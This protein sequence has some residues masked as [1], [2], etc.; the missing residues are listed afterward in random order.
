LANQAGGVASYLAKKLTNKDEVQLMTE[1]L[2]ILT[3]LFLQDLNRIAERQ[4]VV[5]L[6]D[7]YE[8]TGEFLDDWLRAMLDDRYSESVH[9][10]CLVCIAGR[11]PLSRN[12]WT[13][14]EDLIARSELEPFTEEEARRFLAGKQ[15][16]DE[17]VVHEIWRLSSGG[18]PILIAMLAENAP[19]RLEQVNDRCEQAVER[20]LKWEKEEKNRKILLGAALPRLLNR[21]VLAVLTSEAEA[22]E[23]FGWLKGRSFVLEYSEGWRYH[24]IVREQMM[25]CVR[26]VSQKEWAGLHGKLA[27]FY[28]GLRR[29]L[30]LVVGQEWQDETWRSYTLEWLYHSLCAAPQRQLGMALNS[31]LAALRESKGFAEG[32]A[33]AW[34]MAEAGKVADCRALRQWGVTLWSGLNGYC[35]EDLARA[36]RAFSS[37][38][39]APHLE[40]E[41]HAVVLA[42]RGITYRDM[43]RYE[44]ALVDLSR[45]IELD[46]NNKLAIANRGTAYWQ[47]GRFEEAL[48]DLSKAIELDGNDDWAIAGRGI[49]YKLMER[50]EEALVDLSRAIELDGKQTAVIS[51]RGM[52]YKQIDSQEKAL[53]DFNRVIELDSDDVWALGNR[54]EIHKLFERYDEAIADFDRAL[55]LNPNS[56]WMLLERGTTYR[57]IGQY[58]KSLADFDRVLD[59]APDF[60]A[61]RILRG[62]TYQ[63]LERYEEALA[64]FSKVVEF[65]E[66]FALATF[67]C[68]EIY[69]LT[70]QYEQAIQKFDQAIQSDPTNDQYLYRRA[71]AHGLFDQPAESEADLESAIRLAQAKHDQD[72]TDWQNTLHLALYHLVAE[73]PESAVTLYQE[74]IA[75]ASPA[76]IHDA[77]QDLEYLLQLLPDYQ[78]AQEMLRSLNERVMAVE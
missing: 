62:E 8:Q 74:A 68:G 38:L 21:D 16:T 35:E 31:G 45:A 13:D 28:E 54:G 58:D 18:L 41:S 71:F 55:E 22:E 5:L 43:E 20:F 56:T 30:G 48:I 49:T 61:V 6:L 36:V 25:R 66:D 47:I 33:W 78:L 64:D 39:E 24:G 9:P 65:D 29:G 52:I 27:E 44:E 59:I 46:A 75:S 10:N 57:T 7:T 76:Q 23:R 72:P 14:W 26:R 42:Y 50:Y 77:I 34:T 12:A 73:Q 51:L 17:A 63:T 2:E 4:T 1:P 3:P 70:E 19:S 69:W 40:H 11:D 37:L 32:Y 60:N 53:A 15:V 67:K